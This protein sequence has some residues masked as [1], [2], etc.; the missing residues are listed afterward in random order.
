MYSVPLLHKLNV[1]N[2]STVCVCVCVKERKGGSKREYVIVGKICR[3]CKSGLFPQSLW[4]QRLRPKKLKESGCLLGF[5][6]IYRERSDPKIT[7][8]FYSSLIKSHSIK[9]SHSSIKSY[10]QL[11]KPCPTPHHTIR[12]FLSL[13]FCL[14]IY[15]NFSSAHALGM[16]TIM[17]IT[18]CTK[19]INNFSKKEKE[20]AEL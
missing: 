7:T 4:M 14:L 5:C 8:S 17:A 18:H 20:N 16:Y 19:H 2:K 9:P 6:A 3:W 13:D 15:F 11:V 1:K 10:F 12:D